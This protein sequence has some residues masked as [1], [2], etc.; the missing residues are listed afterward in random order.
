MSTLS[1]T[2]SKVGLQHNHRSRQDGRFNVCDGDGVVSYQKAM[3]MK[4]WVDGGVAEELGVLFKDGLCFNFQ[5]LANPKYWSLNKGMSNTVK[6]RRLIT[7]RIN[8][9]CQ[10][11]RM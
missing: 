3:N 11:R 9:D 2:A 6:T 7:N 5:L 8:Q 1:T 4:E 10:L